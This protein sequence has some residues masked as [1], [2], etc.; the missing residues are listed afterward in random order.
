MPNFLSRTVH[1]LVLVIS[2][3]A[4][5]LST[6]GCGERDER[7]VT[8]KY[9]IVVSATVEE[10]SK[11]WRTTLSARP[12]QYYN[13]GPASGYGRPHAVLRGITI[14]IEHESDLFLMVLP[15]Q[16]LWLEEVFQ[17][18]GKSENGIGERGQEYWK[19][20]WIELAMSNER[21]QLPA[22]L[23]PQFVR[24]PVNGETELID[25]AAMEDFGITIHSIELQ[26][27]DEGSLMEENLSLSE[28]Q[29][30]DAITAHGLGNQ[31]FQLIPM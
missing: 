29:L 6:A 11:E 25:A 20:D 5:I 8:M 9:Q 1:L 2:G 13:F 21:S 31:A 15:S 23:F 3:A 26:V 22:E 30:N 14:E 28:K 12:R 4:L 17:V 19:N 24:V 16:S 18:L 7:L 27:V 10:D